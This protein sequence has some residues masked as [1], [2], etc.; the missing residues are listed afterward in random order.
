VRPGAPALD[1]GAP[2]VSR[3]ADLT[4]LVA[5][6]P[7]PP[8]AAPTAHPSADAPDLVIAAP[9]RRPMPS[10]VAMTVPDEAP[11]APAAAPAVTGFPATPAPWPALAAD[12]ERAPVAHAPPTGRW[13]DLPDDSEQR[14]WAPGL[15]PR[16]VDRARRLDREQRGVR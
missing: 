1:A 14:A 4:R 10:L 16:D 11:E 13:P 6:P 2:V 5:A 12:A 3:S 7:P 15:A 9:A 8:I